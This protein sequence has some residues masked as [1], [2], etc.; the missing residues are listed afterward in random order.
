MHHAR[1]ERCRTQVVGSGDGVDVACQVQVE[2]LHRD[3]LRV[4]AAG[5]A[6]LDAER[7]S[8]GRLPNGR[9]HPLTQVR[10][11]CLRKSNGRGRLA[12]AKRRGRDRGYVDVLAIWALLQTIQDL[13]FHLG[14]VRTKQFQ[15]RSSDAQLPATCRIGLSLASCAIS[16]SD[17]TGRRSFSRVGT[18]VDSRARAPLCAQTCRLLLRFSQARFCSFSV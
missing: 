15:L 8:L 5:G 17:G 2:V 6:A 16:M 18:N 10:T 9:H 1:V 3:D 7:R 4:S 14:L 11:E 13:Q 12:F